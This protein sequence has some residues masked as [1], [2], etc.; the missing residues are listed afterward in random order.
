MDTGAVSAER[1]DKGRP[2]AILMAEH[3]VE[4]NLV[5]HEAIGPDLC[6]RGPGGLGDQTEIGGLVA[7]IEE[8]RFPVIAPLDHNVGR[9]GDNEAGE[10]FHLGVPGCIALS[11]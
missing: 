11:I 7:V 8:I 5:E 6:A 1:F 2:Q 4:M 3:H 10:F 9:A